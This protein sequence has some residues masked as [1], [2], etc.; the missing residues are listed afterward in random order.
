MKN[1]TLT[2][3]NSY[4]FR[5]IIIILFSLLTHFFLYFSFSKQNPQ[6]DI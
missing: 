6:F 3:I 4:Q 5:L 1:K 2:I